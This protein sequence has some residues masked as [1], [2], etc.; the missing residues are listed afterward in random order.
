[1]AV[2]II[3]DWQRGRLPFF[4]PPPA[5]GTSVAAPEAPG[6]AGAAAAFES[7]MEEAKV[8]GPA[9]PPPGAAASSGRLTPRDD[10]GDDQ[11]DDQ[12]DDDVEDADGAEVD[13]G[14]ADD[15]AGGSRA[16]GEGEGGEEDEDEVVAP[17]VPSDAFQPR[18]LSKRHQRAK[19][20]FHKLEEAGLDWD[21]L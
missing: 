5:D 7:A 19:A 14:E 20:K 18:P 6:T 4:V 10:D 16:D 21:D 17:A 2:N 13:A 15:G 12:G 9:P 8:H 1:M 11:G 3:N